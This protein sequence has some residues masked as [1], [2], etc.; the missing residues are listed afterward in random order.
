[1][2]LT[3]CA[4][5]EMSGEQLATAIRSEEGAASERVPIV[6]LTANAQPEAAARAIGAGMSAPH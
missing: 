5:P 1:M 4:M 3:D 2:V 6:G